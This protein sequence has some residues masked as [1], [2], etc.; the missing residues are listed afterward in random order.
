MSLILN[1]IDAKCFIMALFIRD[2]GERFLL[3]NGAYEFKDS[4]QHFKASSMENDVVSVQGNDGYLLAGQ[5]RRPTTQS[6]DGYIGDATVSKALIESYR[7]EFIAFFQ[8]NHFYTVVYIL[9]DSTAIQRR[10]GFIVDSPEV[11]ELRQIYPEYHVALNFEDVP[12]YKYAEDSEGNE[13]YTELA[14]IPI[15][16]NTSGGLVWDSLG[17]VWD[18]TGAEWEDGSTGGATTIS[19]DS[20]EVVYPVITITGPTVNPTIENLT[21]ATTAV[22][23]GTITASQTLV[24]NTLDKTVKLNGT[25]VASKLSG[26]IS[27]EPGQNR[28]YYS[29]DNATAP[30]ATLEWQEVVG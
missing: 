5:V 7:R 2:D 3:G 16:T 22:Y 27:L 17:V 29:A 9:P 26:W 24:I 28:I 21:N 1:D 23:T 25:S 13:Q 12:Y 4:Q 20:T 18:E 15:S 30:N 14:T 6:F 19:V 8:K 10:R 11:K